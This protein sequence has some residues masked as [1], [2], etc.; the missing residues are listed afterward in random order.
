MLLHQRVKAR[1]GGQRAIL[2]Y[3]RRR[4]SAPNQTIGWKIDLYDTETT[5]KTNKKGEEEEEDMGANK[6]VAPGKREAPTGT[7]GEDYCT[8]TP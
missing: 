2:S 6:Q 1:K 4:L 8:E 7:K 5:A 3:L